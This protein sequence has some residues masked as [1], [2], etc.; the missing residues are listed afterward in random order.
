MEFGKILYVF[1]GFTNDKL[2]KDAQLNLPGVFFSK[3]T[4]VAS[5]FITN[6]IQQNLRPLASDAFGK[7]SRRAAGHTQMGSGLKWVHWLKWPTKPRRGNPS[8]IWTR[9][10]SGKWSDLAI[11]QMRAT[12]CTP[13]VEC[14]D[15]SRH[16][17]QHM[18]AD[19]TGDAWPDK[20]RRAILL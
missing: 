8:V 12:S 6:T 7:C 2:L 14:T 3:P 5:F 10:F 11:V 9:W 4:M 20:R 13:L 15:L 1:I 17:D 18:G 16:P 19:A